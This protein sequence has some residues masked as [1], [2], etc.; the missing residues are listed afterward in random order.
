MKDEQDLNNFLLKRI[1]EKIHVQIGNEAQVLNNHTLYLFVSNLFD[2]HQA[3]EKLFYQGY[4]T[5]MIETLVEAGVEDKKYLQDEVKMKQLCQVLSKAGFDC[6]DPIWHEQ[7]EVFEIVVKELNTVSN[8]IRTF[9]IGRG[10]IYS[11]NYQKC[12]A[13]GKNILPLSQAPY[14]VVNKETGAELFTTKRRKELLNYIV[15][16]GKKGVQIQR[17]KGLGEMNP[18]QLWETTMNP[19][20]RILL[21]VTVEDA[22]DSDEIFTVLM[23]DQ[24]EP[25]REFIQNNALEVST[26]DI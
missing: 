14:M 1:S 11:S 17:Y 8:Q 4:S 10:L 9:K 6:D 23:G 19:D 13:N 15:E 18:G 5:G 3:L 12:I 22:L 25:R 21:K 26:L 20:K 16:E 24:V 7:R 2:Y